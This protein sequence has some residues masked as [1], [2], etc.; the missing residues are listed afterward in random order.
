[1]NESLSSKW[2][3]NIYVWK[4][5]LLDMQAEFRES[6]GTINN[7]YNN[8]IALWNGERSTQRRR[9]RTAIFVNLKAE[10]YTV[11]RENM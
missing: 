4:G 7:V 1:M 5:L 11:D 10:F 2:R 9:Y 6:T 8:Y 3:D